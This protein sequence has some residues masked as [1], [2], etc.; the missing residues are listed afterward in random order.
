MKANGRPVDNSK[1]LH[2]VSTADRY[3]GDMNFEIEGDKVV[4]IF[5]VVDS[6]ASTSSLKFVWNPAHPYTCSDLPGSRY[7]K[8]EK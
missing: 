1:V 5:G 8:C 6:E 2:F 7:A 3:S 4:R